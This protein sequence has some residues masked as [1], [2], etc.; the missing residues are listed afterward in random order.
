MNWEIYDMHN[1]NLT[2]KEFAENY[3]NF[4]YFEKPITEISDNDLISWY[5][6]FLNESDRNDP[7]SK[8]EYDMFHEECEN[9]S[10]KFN[11][12]IGYLDSVL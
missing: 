10:V 11:Y 8:V 6:V 4:S 5:I 2:T 1:E 12:I 9:R 7:Q 3:E